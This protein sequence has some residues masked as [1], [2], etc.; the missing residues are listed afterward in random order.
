M[1][2]AARPRLISNLVGVRTV[3]GPHAPFKKTDGLM[4]GSVP[5]ALALEKIPHNLEDAPLYRKELL[6]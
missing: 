2:R 3:S 1:R 4:T 5:M 6:T